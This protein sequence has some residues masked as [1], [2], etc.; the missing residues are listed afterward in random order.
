MGKLAIAVETFAFPLDNG[1]TIRGEVKAVPDGRPKAAVVAGHGFRGHK[2]WAFWTDVTRQLAESGFY[3]V[4]FDFSRVSTR[5]EGA[6]E[7]RVAEASTLTQELADLEAVVTRLRKGELPL[8]E[9][10]DA[11]RI[12]LLG[13]SRAGGSGILLASERPEL[14]KALVVW[15]GGVLPAPSDGPGLTLQE[16]VIGEDLRANANRFRIAEAFVGLTIPALVVQGDRDREELIAQ[17]KS[18]REKAPQ[19]QYL[20]IEGADHVFN[21]IH[22]YAG[23]TGQLRKALEG[24]IRFL[25]E[26]L[27]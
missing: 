27:D 3:A 15:N 18:F 23:A 16:R 25:K 4:G 7:K 5:S 14:L 21:T 13:H 9:Q 20:F 10:A 8:A 1:L 12:A 26:K 19:Q 2:D 11:E 17:I 24:T 22:P 6:D